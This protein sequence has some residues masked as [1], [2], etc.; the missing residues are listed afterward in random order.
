[1]RVDIVSSIGTDRD[2]NLAFHVSRGRRHGSIWIQD[3]EDSD[4]ECAGREGTHDRH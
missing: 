1:M 4:V 3:N 2:F